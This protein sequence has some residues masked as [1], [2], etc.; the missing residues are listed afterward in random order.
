MPSICGRGAV[1]RKS[2]EAGL[3]NAM[4]VLPASTRIVRTVCGAAA[5]ISTGSVTLVPS[6]ATLSAP[7]VRP[8]GGIACTAVTPASPAPLSVS[9]TLVPI[10]PTAGVMP[11]AAGGTTTPTADE[12]ALK[13]WLTGCAT[14]CFTT[15]T[16]GATIGVNAACTSFTTLKV[17]AGLAAASEVPAAVVTVTVRGPVGASADTLTASVR[18]VP[19]ALTDGVELT[20]I[21]VDGVM[22]TA[23]VVCK[24]LPRTVSVM[25]VVPATA[26]FGSSESTC[27]TGVVMRT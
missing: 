23:C 3:E 1:T 9:V 22:L 7:S 20:V 11:V 4:L 8:S 15:P 16:T 17:L 21:P 12:N 26:K 27:G 6:G 5:A 18:V 2:A 24:F 19:S 25:A 13:V 10:I 14:S